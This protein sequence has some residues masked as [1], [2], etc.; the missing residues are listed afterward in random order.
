M[1]ENDTK[2]YVSSGRILTPAEIARLDKIEARMGDSVDAPEMSDAAW[3]AARRKKR[4]IPA[5]LHE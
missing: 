4:P 3:S 1:N 5:A 2:Y